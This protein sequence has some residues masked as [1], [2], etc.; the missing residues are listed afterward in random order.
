MNTLDVDFLSI[1]DLDA[2]G[3]GMMNDGRGQ[4][5]PKAPGAYVPYGGPGMSV[6]QTV[7]ELILTG[8][9]VGFVLGL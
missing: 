7:G 4:M 8:V 9:A 5:D 1:D 3:G 2:V 6:G